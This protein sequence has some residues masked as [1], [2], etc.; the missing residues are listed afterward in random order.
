MTTRATRA[1]NDCGNPV[2]QC[3]CAVA[4]CFTC[5]R[6]DIDGGDTEYRPQSVGRR[7]AEEHRAAGHDVRDLTCNLTGNDEPCSPDCNMQAY[8]E[9]FPPV[10]ESNALFD[11]NGICRDCGGTVETH[12]LYKHRGCPVKRI[13]L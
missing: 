5:S 13:D 7:L 12:A 3:S 1:C 2:E 9:L 11:N 10:D 4:T 6:L 8:D